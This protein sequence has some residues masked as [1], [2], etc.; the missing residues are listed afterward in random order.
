MATWTPDPTFY[1][2]PRMAMKA[3]QETLAYVA[4]FDPA[5]QVPD[6]IAV[7]DVDPASPSYTHDRRHASRCRR[8]ATNSI[9]SAGTPA[10]PAYA[11]TRRIPTSSGG[12]SSCRACGPR[13]STFWIS[14][15]TRAIRTLSK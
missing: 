5:R 13:A 1:P 7:V 8:R 6:A 11:R 15:Q 4:S 9:I 14:S 2:S 10:A 3:P 12:T